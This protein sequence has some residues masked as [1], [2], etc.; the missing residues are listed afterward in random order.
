MLTALCG[1]E[2]PHYLIHSQFLRGEAPYG[3]FLSWET[4]FLAGSSRVS[5][6]ITGLRVT[7]TIAA[8]SLSI[9][10]LMGLVLESWPPSPAVALEKTRD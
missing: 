9:K 3:L 2:A 10:Y 6:Y 1:A 7:L 8:I 5:P 4:L